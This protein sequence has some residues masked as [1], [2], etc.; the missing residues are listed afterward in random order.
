M[1][2]AAPP[3]GKSPLVAVLASLIL[4]FMPGGVFV[5][6][7]HTDAKLTVWSAY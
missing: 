4:Y 3:P 7:T 1:K 5:N 6:C 2:A